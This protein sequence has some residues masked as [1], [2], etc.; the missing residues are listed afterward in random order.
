MLN[1]FFV[2]YFKQTSVCFYEYSLMFAFTLVKRYYTK[3]FLFKTER[4]YVLK[5]DEF[6]S[7]TSDKL[8]NRFTLILNCKF[9]EHV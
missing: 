4:C 3:F 8:I 1:V 2:Y 7:F 6:S 5:E 9:I